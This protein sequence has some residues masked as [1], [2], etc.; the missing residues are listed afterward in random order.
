LGWTDPG[1]R[2]LSDNGEGQTQQELRVEKDAS[3]FAVKAANGG[4]MEVEAGK[5]AE[6]KGMSPRVKDF[7]AMMVK[8][9]GEANNKLKSVASSLNIA[10]PESVSNDAKKD[11]EK[12]DK[13]N[14]KDFDKAYVDMMVDDHEKDVAEFRKAADNCSDSTLR[15]FA[16]QTLPVLEKHLDSIKSIA[17]KK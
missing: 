9:H 4:L 13:K 12:L 16:R 11:I 8:D 15:E 10:L 6:D 5:L 2:W 1:A 17:G 3:D 14:G 7:G